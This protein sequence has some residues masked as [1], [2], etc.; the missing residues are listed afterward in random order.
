LLE[1]K[2]T[3]KEWAYVSAEKGNLY[4][5]LAVF[6]PSN[7][8]KTSRENT[9][10]FGALGADLFDRFSVTLGACGGPG[11]NNKV[12][13]ANTHDM[14]NFGT[15]GFA[16]YNPQERNFFFKTRT[17]V[18]DVDQNFYVPGFSNSVSN[19]FLFPPFFFP[20]FTPVESKGNLSLMLDGVGTVE[21]GLQEIDMRIGGKT[22]L[23]RIGIG[24]YKTSGRI[25]PS[26]MY[27]SPVKAGPLNGVLEFS[28]D[29]IRG[30]GSYLSLGIDF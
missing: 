4:G 2:K 12:L 23:G 24:A 6:G 3:P 7:L 22:S 1:R 28:G 13:V 29:R 27:Y 25:A 30:L 26:F 21:N 10:I 11:F 9:D 16:V 8:L 17:A 5:M 19:L 14:E 20:H 18:G 15:F